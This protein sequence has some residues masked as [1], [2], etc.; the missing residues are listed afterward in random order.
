MTLI[1]STILD[2][3]ASLHDLSQPDH[4]LDQ[5]DELLSQTFKLNRGDITGFGLDCGVCCF[6]KKERALRFA[7][8]KSNLY[9]K[10]GEN[11]RE[12]KGDKVSLGYDFKEHPIP[13]KVVETSLD[14][15]SSFYMFSDGIT[16][17]IG[18]KK[19]LMYGKKRLLHQIQ[20]SASVAEAIERI[21]K[22]LKGYQA[23]NNRRDDLTLFGFSF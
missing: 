22:D 19:K 12:I 5:L 21:M 4:L 18:G 11:V 15:K 23:D 1:S 9:Q 17:Q 7:G 13:F 20:S 3:I 8:A 10:V 6:S 2:R 14:E 16:D